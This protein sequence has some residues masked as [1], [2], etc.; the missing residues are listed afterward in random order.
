MKVVTLLYMVVER[1][2]QDN[3]KQLVQ[4]LV[5]DKGSI[6]HSISLGWFALGSLNSYCCLSLAGVENADRQCS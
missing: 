3:T 5:Q 6:M 1:L 4:G 2:K